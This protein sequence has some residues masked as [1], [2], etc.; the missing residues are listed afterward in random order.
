MKTITILTILVLGACNFALSQPLA[1]DA[2]AGLSVFSGG[3]SSTALDLSAGVEIPIQQ[4]L[5]FRP[6]LDITTHNGTPIEITGLLKFTLPEATASFPIYVDGG[7][8]AWFY[9]GGS[10]LGL[11]FGGG[12][13]FSASE[14]KMQIPLEIRM[15]PIF[16]SGASSFQLSLCTGV[17]FS[18]GN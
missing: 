17:R 3:G 6:G 15:G 13:Y 8:A 11:D 18:L 5:A 4:N 1:V 12:T 7:L 14:G 2:K 10:S 9:S 16:D